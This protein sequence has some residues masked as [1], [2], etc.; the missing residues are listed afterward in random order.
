[1]RKPKLA[2]RLLFGVIAV[3]MVVGLGNDSLPVLIDHAQKVEAELISFEKKVNQQPSLMGQ[4][5][6]HIRAEA[7]KLLLPLKSEI[8]LEAIK[9][10]SA[11]G[12][13]F[14]DQLMVITPATL[15]YVNLLARVYYLY[16]KA[17]HSPQNDISKMSFAQLSDS[18]FIDLDLKLPRRVAMLIYVT[19]NFL[20]PRHDVE[21]PHF[22]WITLPQSDRMLA[23]M[24]ALSRNEESDL[25]LTNDYVSEG[26]AQSGLI[27]RYRDSVFR[28]KTEKEYAKLLQFV[29][30]RETLFNRWVINRLRPHPIK[31]TTVNS[32]G[33]DGYLSFKTS[34]PNSAELP[35]QL[36]AYRGWAEQE[37]LL[38]ELKR[39]QEKVFP[40]V[41]RTPLATEE[42]HADV[43]LSVMKSLPGYEKVRARIVADHSVNAQ[44]VDAF[45]KHSLVD[46]EGKSLG[47]RIRENVTS[48]WNQ[49]DEYDTKKVGEKVIFM[50]NHPSDPYNPAQ[51][52]RRVA[53]FSYESMRAGAVAQIT[54]DLMNNKWVVYDEADVSSYDRTQASIASLAEKLY[55]E[56]F[57]S[58]FLTQVSALAQVPYEQMRN[59]VI[60]AQGN[61]WNL[62]QKA[63]R[64]FESVKPVIPW[65]KEYRELRIYGLRAGYL[66]EYDAFGVPQA[67]IYHHHM[68]NQNSKVP[69]YGRVDSFS[70]VLLALQS[71]LSLEPNQTL[72]DWLGISDPEKGP[73]DP[74]FAHLFGMWA[75]D[76]A[77]EYR[78]LTEDKESP[79]QGDLARAFKKATEKLRERVKPSMKAKLGNWVDQQ[80][81]TT[82]DTLT[83]EAKKAIVDYLTK[84]ITASPPAKPVASQPQVMSKEHVE[85]VSKWIKNLEPQASKTAGPVAGEALIKGEIKRDQIATGFVPGPKLEIKVEKL[86][87]ALGLASDISADDEQLLKTDFDRMQ[88]AFFRMGEAMVTQPMLGIP[89]VDERVNKLML[90]PDTYRGHGLSP[91]LSTGK[92]AR[93]IT[94]GDRVRQE[95]LLN[96]DFSSDTRQY[97]RLIEQIAE[98]YTP[99]A[100]PPVKLTDHVY[101]E[102]KLFKLIERAVESAA[103]QGQGLF[104]TF[105]KA[106]P[107]KW[108][109]DPNFK[110][111]FN[112]SLT[113]RKAMTSIDKNLAQ[114]DAKLQKELRSP[115]QKFQ[116]DWL[117]PIMNFLF[118]A[119]IIL[120]AIS[121]PLSP[122][123]VVGARLIPFVPKILMTLGS[124]AMFWGFNG[125]M[126]GSMVTRTYVNFYEKPLDV[127]FAQAVAA[128]NFGDADKTLMSWSETVGQQ[129]KMKADQKSAMIQNAFDGIFAGMFVSQIKFNSG[130]QSVKAAEEL[131]IPLLN[132]QQRLAESMTSREHAKKLLEMKVSSGGKKPSRM[133]RLSQEVD[134]QTQRML[135]YLP[136]YQKVTYSQATEAY[137]NIV[138]K[139]LPKNLSVIDKEFEASAQFVAKRYANSSMTFEELMQRPDLNAFWLMPRNWLRNAKQFFKTGKV[140]YLKLNQGLTELIEDTRLL[141]RLEIKKKLDIIENIRLKK[142]DAAKI[143][144]G[145]VSQGEH[146]ISTLT[147]QELA[148]F[149]D[150]AHGPGWWWNRWATGFKAIYSNEGHELGELYRA[151]SGPYQNYKKVMS[152]FVDVSYQ[153]MRSWWG[154]DVE[155]LRWSDQGRKLYEFEKALSSQSRQANAQFD[156]DYLQILSIENTFKDLADR[157][158]ISRTSGKVLKPLS[159]L[160]EA[161]QRLLERYLRG[162]NF[163]LAM[164]EAGLDYKNAQHISEFTDV[165]QYYEQM[166]VLD[167]VKSLE[168]PNYRELWKRL[169]DKLGVRT[170]P[171]EQLVK[172]HKPGSQ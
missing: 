76:A 21:D 125:A 164:T 54:S 31:E 10:A 63:K 70:S 116:E 75:E 128:Q 69:H 135:R 97:S 171:L 101:N 108:D 127:K 45:L 165:V 115:M 30:L 77:S 49:M 107:K 53:L 152:G 29:T 40:I 139:G 64:I 146:F 129:I 26:Q 67:P 27:E 92:D 1:M 15:R 6:F 3:L 13:D 118:Y 68:L 112:A 100:V 143:V 82:P 102:E 14:D 5:G 154:D 24:F 28:V 59:P 38:F 147:D 41:G 34:T 145:E 58:N 20:T 81:I 43:L 106:D 114:I 136:K 62:E 134:R 32:C 79:D 103:L 61:H 144:D 56:K 39:V 91:G 163:K 156:L 119:T 37:E 55:D 22:W 12:A 8:E 123:A 19:G 98:I 83:H 16:A 170:K 96:L 105:C 71:R 25:A 73:L 131:G 133:Q 35:T 90:E 85:N 11:Q 121:F 149:S 124:A 166:Q 87:Q 155:Y 60:K 4:N 141:Q 72:A 51:M 113:V 42:Q 9:T 132:K 157:G 94:R 167:R 36:I 160:T 162:M 158:I 169:N 150:M 99:L 161:D 137:R 66:K 110:K 122:L 65:I 153:P 23:E 89:V 168:D 120:L 57:K 46:E 111:V 159:A 78:R 88:Y 172:E 140:E 151:V 93:V 84:P 52:A 130:L 47:R 104:E 18:R 109:D 33:N 126:I 74:E 95:R 2:H 44:S 50:S 86:L 48:Y 138:G 7:R 117:A 142:A 148:I 80:I 17:A